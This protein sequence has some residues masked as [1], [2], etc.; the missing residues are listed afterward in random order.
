[1]IT[2][3]MEEIN[4]DIFVL[5]EIE[6]GSLDTVAEYLNEVDAGLYKTAYGTTGGDQRVVFLYDME[7]VKASSTPL[8]LFKEERPT[9][10]TGKD[11]FP[12]LPFHSTFVARAEREP[13]DFHLVGVHL[14]FQRGGG[15]DQRRMA[16]TFLAKWL[17]EHTQDEDAIIAGDWNADSKAEE[18]KALQELENRGEVVFSAWNP[19]H[20]ASHLSR[21]GRSSRLDM[22][23]ITP[24]VEDVSVTDK[25]TVI[26]WKVLQRKR[27]SLS[28]II[29]KLSDHL[30]VVSRFYFHD[31]D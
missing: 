7:W 17:T 2:R 24:G 5:Q 3:I 16:A 20:E 22:I 21:S 12:R 8:E 15:D 14:K 31:R 18:W 28:F 9:T 6:E 1:M 26:S 19:A 11:V 23:V 30:P 13:F 10:G 25:A 4:A 29:D 27:E